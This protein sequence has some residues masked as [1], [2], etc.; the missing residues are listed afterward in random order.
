MNRSSARIGPMQG[1]PSGR[2][3]RCQRWYQQERL[4]RGEALSGPKDPLPSL[5]KRRIVDPIG[6]RHD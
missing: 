1:R 5:F 6:D 2:Q 4:I 3:A